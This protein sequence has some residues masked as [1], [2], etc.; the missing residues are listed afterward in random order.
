MSVSKIITE[1]GRP[2]LYIDGKKTLPMLYGMS[3]IPASR[4]NTAMSQRNMR[5]FAEAGIKLVCCDVAISTEWHKY[6]PFETNSI[7]AEIAGVLAAVPDAGVILRL[8]MN[9]PYWWIRDNKEEQVKYRDENGDCFGIDNGEENRLIAHNSDDCMNVSLCSEKWLCEAGEKLKI[10]IEDLKTCEEGNA[11]VGIQIAGGMFGEWHPFGNGT[12]VGEAAKRGFAKYLRSTYGTEEALRAAWGNESVTF[13]NAPFHPENFLPAEDGIFRDPKSARY[14]T[15]AQKF[16]QANTAKDILYFCRIVKEAWSDVLVGSFYGYYILMASERTP[17]NGHLEFARLAG[18]GCIDF[19]CGPFPYGK[20]RET[21]GVPLMRGLLESCRLNGILWLTEMDDRPDGLEDFPRGGDPALLGST[22]ARLRRYVYQNALAGMGMWYYDHRVVPSLV[23]KGKETSKAATIY[24]KE[25]WWDTEKLMGEI[26]G[27]AADCSEI[28]E[29][30][31]RPVS[32]V[33]VVLGTEQFC[34]MTRPAF[35]EYPIFEA[36]ARSG[37]AYDCIYFSDLEKAEMSRYKLVIFF[38]TYF[39]SRGDREKVLSLTEK[40]ARLW[41]YAP[42]YVDAEGLSTEGISGLSGMKIGKCRHEDCHNVFLSGATKHFSGA[43]AKEA[44]SFFIGEED[45]SLEVLAR[46]GDGK[47]SAAIKGKE[48]FF[49]YP[50]FD[51]GIF[52]TLARRFG[53][54]I[55]TEDDGCVFAEGGFAAV[56]FLSPGKKTVTLPGG[57]VFRFREEDCATELIRDGRIQER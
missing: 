51:C 50:A 37:A 13:E 10:L 21:G 2:T 5:N 30:P 18:S 29:K 38:N 20:N 53:V 34:R 11:V 27:L 7:R 33:L 35:D 24:F 43:L 52:R 28:Y 48:L 19:L 23:K 6:Y 9:P 49:A 39:M 46:Y 31:Y 1:N 14:I 16:L 45:A 55:Y 44:P 25:G 22:L 41:L 3:D 36:I 40:C 26:A 32:D 4:S 47:V 56:N 42:G 8:H 54:H 57:K 12:D 15:D 17:L